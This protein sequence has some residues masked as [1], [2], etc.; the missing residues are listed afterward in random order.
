MS[1]SIYKQALE[2]L[3][4]VRDMVR[5]AASCFSKG[6][7]AFGHGNASAWDEAAYLVMHALGL[8][9]TELDPSLDARLTHS[10]MRTI[11]DIIQRRCLGV[12]AAYLTREAWLGP[13]RFYVDERAII[14]RS[15]IAELLLDGLSPWVPQPESVRRVLDSL[16][17]QKLH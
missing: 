12:P 16:I 7:L 9:V 2:Q 6:G 3:H 15:F 4:T 17:E 10:E 13:Y 1:R 11:I 5:F 8:A 14:P